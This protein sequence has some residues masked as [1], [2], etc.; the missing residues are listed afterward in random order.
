MPPRIDTV[1]AFAKGLAVIGSFGADAR[2]QTI[3]EV[4]ARTG[5]TR[6]GA[7]RFLH[8]LVETGHARTDGKHFELTVRVLELGEA[9][10][11]GFAELT[12]ARDVVRDLA[13]DHDAVACA[14]ALD[15]ADV[16][17]VAC[18]TAEAG[19]P[20]LG[21]A[22]GARRP[23][24]SSA[25]G[26]ALLAQLSATE[27]DRLSRATKPE[28]SPGARETLRARLAEVRERGWASV[29]DG[30]DPASAWIAVAVPPLSPSLRL[31][32][33]LRV[34]IDDGI[35]RDDALA[36]LRRAAAEIV[37]RAAR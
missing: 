22:V 3:S 20:R 34:R 37:R 27:F 35:R 21:L 33:A 13:R 10:A 6:A 2:R 36:A 31:A 11:T 15:G 29:A 1:A 25:T 30:V 23:A 14:T 18:S 12:I 9:Y 16:V 19:P 8:T 24:R 26:S 5:L 4:A 17:C 7:R 32:V 28:G